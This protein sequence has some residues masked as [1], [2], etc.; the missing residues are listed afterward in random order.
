[1]N[2]FNSGFNLIE[3]LIALSIVGIL[4]VMVQPSYQKLVAVYHRHQ[5][6]SE[7]YL[8]R[9]WVEQYYLDYEQWPSSIKQLSSR[10]PKI[11]G[12]YFSL[13]HSSL[14]RDRLDIE[15][16]ITFSGGLLNSCR[17][18]ILSVTDPSHHLECGT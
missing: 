6:E 7:L 12:V 17:L 14:R 13:H 18:L 11:P 8:I 16:Q 15:A 9:D 2:R 5:V 3:L 10:P 4:S 1:M